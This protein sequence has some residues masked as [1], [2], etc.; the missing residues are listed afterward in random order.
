MSVLVV[1]AHPDDEVLCCAGALQVCVDIGR[2]VRVV[3]CSTGALSRRNAKRS[4]AVRLAKA[5][6]KVSKFLELEPPFLLGLPDNRLDSMDR[7][8]LARRIED[9]IAH[10]Q[11]S[12]VYTHWPYDLNIDHRRVAEAVLV[13]TRPGASSVR[14]VFFCE[15]LSSTEWA[16]SLPA[17]APN[18]YVK[19]SFAQV[20]KKVE[21]MTRFYNFEVRQAHPRSPAAINALASLRGSQSGTEFAE[22][23]VLARSIR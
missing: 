7:L 2:R 8:D 18:V 22:A 14:N 13:A 15:A 1:V 23:F 21:A 9:V 16:Y 6:R 12:D 17:F 10:D 5:A 3:I 20:Q 11:P 19:L 4:D